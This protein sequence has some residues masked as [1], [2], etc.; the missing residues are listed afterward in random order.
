MGWVFYPDN[1]A[2]SADSM[3]K[4]EFNC[5]GTN[6]TE[7]RVID[8]ATRGNAWYAILESVSPDTGTRY[9]GTVCLFRRSKRT[10]EFGY[11]D[12]GESV[13]PNAANAPLRIIDKLDKLCPIDANDD[14]LGA[15]WARDWRARC[16]ANAKAKKTIKL[17]PG[18]R[19]AFAP[20]YDRE[21]V[22]VSSAGPRRGWHVRLAG[23][24]D[25]IYRAHAK[26]FKNCSIVQG[27]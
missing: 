5:T 26:L 7:W 4:R 21:Y 25:M 15:K 14:S 3:L 1:A 8:S 18:M 27:V 10:G 9:H 16:R 22:L 24:S 13:G 11:K 23:G 6:G 20:A 2:M 12:I 17:A 19:V